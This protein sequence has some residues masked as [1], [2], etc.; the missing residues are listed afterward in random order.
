M[1]NIRLDQ[2]RSVIRDKKIKK[3]IVDM[4][5]SYREAM[6]LKPLFKLLKALKEESIAVL[7]TQRGSTNLVTFEQNVMPVEAEIICIIHA[8]AVK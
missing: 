7:L 5:I 1:N 6:E 2:I 3:V 4:V 8:P